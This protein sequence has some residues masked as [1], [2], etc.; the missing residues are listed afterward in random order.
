MDDIDSALI[1]L[2]REDARAPA[3]LLSRKLGLSRTTVQ[4]RIERLERR[5][6][7]SGY[8]LRLSDEFE[9]GLIK[10]QV[11]IVALPKLSAQVEAALRAI[12]EVRA[13]HSLSGSYDMVALVAAGSIREMDALIDRIGALDGVE[14]TMSSIILSTKFER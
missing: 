12:R 3:A 1:A 13:L 5:G 9:Q 2:L 4:H 6:V 7:I 14:R 10:A 8:T 11:M